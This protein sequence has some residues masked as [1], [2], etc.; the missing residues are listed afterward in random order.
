MTD[1]RDGTET[2]QVGPIVFSHPSAR[3]QLTEHGEVVTFRTS[4]R[5][6]GE[7]WWR[8]SRTGEKRGDVTVEMIS[9]VD[10]RTPYEL[11]PT[12]HLSGFDSVGDWMD[13][14]RELNGGELPELGYLY[15]VEAIQ[16][17]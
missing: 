16:I 3:G 2:Q 4:E 15:R 10:P 8:A 5:T 1:E 13:A 9:P 6:T 14:I 11:T 17:Q 7:T 12:Q